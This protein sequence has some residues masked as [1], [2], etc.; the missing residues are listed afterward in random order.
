MR[1]AAFTHQD[2]RR[3]RE[4]GGKDKFTWAE[5]PNSLESYQEYFKW[6][7]SIGDMAR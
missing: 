3:Q 1:Q 4:S 2:A 5:A 7:L 6:I